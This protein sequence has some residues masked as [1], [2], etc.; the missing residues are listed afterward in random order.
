MSS[1]PSS[2]N[3]NASSTKQHTVTQH[4]LDNRS[5]HLLHLQQWTL[6]PCHAFVTSLPTP[7][8]Y[9]VE[10]H[11]HSFYDW[12]EW[13]TNLL[14]PTLWNFRGPWSNLVL[15]VVVGAPSS[16]LSETQVQ[17][18]EPALVTAIVANV[19]ARIVQ[20]PVQLL[21]TEHLNWITSVASRQRMVYM[22][23]P[24]IV[25]LLRLAFALHDM[26]E[27]ARCVRPP[28][29]LT[30]TVF[31]NDVAPCYIV[32][33][34]L[35]RIEM[36]HDFVQS[37]I[38]NY[39]LI[40]KELDQLVWPKWYCSFPGKPPSTNDALHRAARAVVVCIPFDT[41]D[42]HLWLAQSLQAEHWH[43]WARLAQVLTSMQVLSCL[44]NDDKLH[45]EACSNIVNTF[46]SLYGIQFVNEHQ[47]K[48]SQLGYSD[49]K[50]TLRRILDLAVALEHFFTFLVDLHKHE[51]S[52]RQSERQ[53]LLQWGLLCYETLVRMLAAVRDILIME[54][55]RE[56]AMVDWTACALELAR[57]YN[58]CV[59]DNAVPCEEVEQ[60]ILNAF[61]D[62][63]WSQQTRMMRSLIAHPVAFLQ[64]YQS[65]I[66]TN[67]TS[68]ISSP[69]MSSIS[70]SLM[71]RDT[72]SSEDGGALVS[73]HW[74]TTLDVNDPFFRAVAVV[75]WDKRR[76]LQLLDTAIGLD[77]ES[78]ADIKAGSTGLPLW[79]HRR[80]AACRVALSRDSR[81]QA[82][83]IMERLHALF[84][85]KELHVGG[86]F[87]PNGVVLLQTEALQGNFCAQATYG[88]LLAGSGPFWD[89]ARCWANCKQQ[90]EHG[91]QSL[92]VS[93][94]AGDLEASTALSHIWAQSSPES[95]CAFSGVS[96]EQV[97]AIFRKA[98][99]T[100]NAKAVLN[101]GVMW[102]YGA[103][104]VD[105][106]IAVAIDAFL[107]ALQGGPS[108]DVRAIAASHLL[109]IVMRAG[110]APVRSAIM[111]ALERF[112]F[113]SSE[114]VK[115][116]TSPLR[117]DDYQ[118]YE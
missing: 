46:S 58:T 96:V 64:G 115:S 60:A 67:A 44:P 109:E 68:S 107:I 97:H 18:I 76:A 11:T 72:A 56:M 24:T 41:S 80:I 32:P 94:M 101:M 77:A 14:N 79:D 26:V 43:H 95:D 118:G 88:L 13:V 40:N 71:A 74:L 70:A 20:T 52:A 54:N 34:I 111:S 105:K 91:V 33:A 22:N 47:L 75:Q 116:A 100:Q 117:I 17:R 27:Y 102:R 106:Q 31:G 103:P 3:S 15:A 8:P 66:S 53:N 19:V 49:T 110:S 1:S 2:P 25:I 7:V 113:A 104:R 21:T 45:G 86:T 36:A 12:A 83:L 59:Q 62:A 5:S 90:V 93:G 50:L 112:M 4:S 9:Q 16:A 51:H 29:L 78:L 28:R 10:T 92:Y 114:T 84:E 65:P 23:T 57:Y 81:Q 61:C 69:L 82:A 37:V 73:R 99:A 30:T 42:M 38:A 108:R 48:R 85:A 39:T 63:S 55:A 89:V 98:V 87:S 35:C 6:K